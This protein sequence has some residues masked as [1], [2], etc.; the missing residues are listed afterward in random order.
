MASR[1]EPRGEAHRVTAELSAGKVPG[2]LAGKDW[3]KY[4]GLLHTDNAVREEFFDGRET[5][6]T[7]H[8]P[9]LMDFT[10]LYDSTQPDFTAFTAGRIFTEEEVFADIDSPE[11]WTHREG[12]YEPVERTPEQAAEVA[13]LLN[14]CFRWGVIED[15]PSA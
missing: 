4:E 14:A 3:T 9:H 7:E 5:P 8:K 12:G 13:E 2:Q 11:N 10:Y 1:P 15:R 6:L